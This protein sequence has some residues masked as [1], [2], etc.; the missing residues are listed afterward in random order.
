MFGATIDVL[1]LTQNLTQSADAKL[2]AGGMR[3][4][5]SQPLYRP[6]GKAIPVLTRFAC[7]C[8]LK[9]LTIRSISLGFGS[10][11]RLVG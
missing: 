2:F 10:P 5:L 4:M 8:L 1:L 9:S 7:Q 3:Q 6:D 11:F